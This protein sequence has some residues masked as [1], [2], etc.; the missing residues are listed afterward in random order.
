M[1]L[2]PLVAAISAALGVTLASSTAL[3]DLELRSVEFSGMKAPSSAEQ[4][5][6]IYTDAKV[7][8]TYVNDGKKIVEHVY[9]LRY[10][11]LMGTTDSV[12]GRIVGGLYDVEGQPLT[13]NDGQMA[14][15]AADGTSLLDIPG[16][17]A[18]NP[19]K[20]RPL[21]MVVNFEYKELPPN[22]PG[23]L[24]SSHWSRLPAVIGVAKLDQDKR[25]GRLD[26]M[27]Y[28]PVDFSKVG[29]G[30][31]HCGSTPSPGFARSGSMTPRSTRTRKSMRSRRRGRTT[32]PTSTAS[33]TT[34]SA[35]APRTC[36]TRR[37]RQTRP[38]ERWPARLL[39]T[40]TTTALC[41]K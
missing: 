23:V 9:D 1:K 29:G 15:D 39:R 38:R 3:A 35:T 11:Q 40:R 20:A 28:G 4:K 12:N 21:A 18:G 5:A 24:K 25:T 22:S 41:P 6:D 30:W 17:R 2:K 16:M 8:Y 32:P 13:D 27:D 14:S 10:H 31:I 26:V 34:T 37:L 36:P 19:A 7:K 33:A